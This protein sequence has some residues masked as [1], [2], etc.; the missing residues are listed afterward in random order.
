[1]STRRY[2]HVPDVDPTAPS[3][4][5]LLLHPKITPPKEVDHREYWRDVFDQGQTS[6]CVG[7]G[8]AS[9]IDARICA[10]V[11][12]YKGPR[13]ARKFPYDIARILAKAHASDAITDDGCMPALA[14][15]GLLQWGIPREED[16]PF[17]PDAINL[18]P[19]DDVGIEAMG[20]RIDSVRRIYSKG[21]A[22]IDDLVRALANFYPVPYGQKVDKTFEE[23]LDKPESAVMGPFKGA[24]L[25]N[26]CTCFAGYRTYNTGKR[27]LLFGNSWGRAFGHNGF[28]WVGEDRVKAAT[29]DHYAIEVV[30]NLS[31]E[32]A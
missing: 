1:M 30:P 12:G 15:Q 26:H 13:P 25:G 11:P 9:G 2:G 24:N 28:A 16:W 7:H 3:M 18:E 32:A 14:A 4:T 22:L 31:L 10:L 23:W 5:S 21:D 20:Y 19:P 27:D 17:S 29:F 8:W 6:A